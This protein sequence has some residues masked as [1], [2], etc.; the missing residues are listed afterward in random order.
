MK[1]F[2][3]A[4]SSL[5][6]AKKAADTAEAVLEQMSG[7]PE[8]PLISYEEVLADL[9]RRTQINISMAGFHVD[10][11]RAEALGEDEPDDTN[12]EQSEGL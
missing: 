3:D 11:A 8:R 12:H 4:M 1:E 7:T 6:R 2:Y 5:T 10:Q 9:I